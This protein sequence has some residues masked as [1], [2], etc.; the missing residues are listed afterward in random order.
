MD[1]W[2]SLGEGYGYQGDELALY[3]IS[4]PFCME[5]GN[6]GKAFHAEKKQPN[7]P[8]LLNFD[9]LQCGSCAS[10]VQVFWSATRGLHDYRVQPWPLK[11]EK[12]PEHL[13]G[14]VGRYWLQA[15]KSLTDKNYDAAAVMT[16]SAIQTALREHK[17]QGSNLKQEIDDLAA[18]GQLPP[19]MQEWA[20][21]VRELGNDS[22]HPQPDQSPTS[23][24]DARDIV[25]FMDFLFEYLYALP[26]RINEFRERK[27]V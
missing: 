13:T 1:S 27:P 17:A 5:S 10:F 26:K 7:G 22:A 9:T 14:T 6:F 8:K 2:W 11:Y 21:S 12:A 3:R 23:A 4:C 19:L 24:Q 15:K 16:R 25:R 18:K 20:H